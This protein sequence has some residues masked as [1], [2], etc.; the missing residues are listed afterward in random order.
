MH[1]VCAKTERQREKITN[2]LNPFV[3]S[4]SMYFTQPKRIPKVWYD[5]HNLETIVQQLFTPKLKVRMHFDVKQNELRMSRMPSIDTERKEFIPLPKEY[6]TVGPGKNGGTVDGASL[7]M[8]NNHP[9]TAIDVKQQKSATT[10][11]FNNN[12]LEQY[13]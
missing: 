8:E 12:I 2:V 11:Q 6:L 4:F 7:I 1:Q 9:E 13:T 3:H 5:I 10:D